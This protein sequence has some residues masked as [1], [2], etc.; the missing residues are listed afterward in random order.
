MRTLTPAYMPNGWV[1]RV[2]K[3]YRGQYGKH[4]LNATEVL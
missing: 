1:S 3:G 4:Y 2:F